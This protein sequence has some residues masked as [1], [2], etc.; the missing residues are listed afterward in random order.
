MLNDFR[1]GQYISVDSFIHK[2]DPRT[3]LLGLGI[4][5]LLVFL[6]EQW[7]SITG[8]ILLTLVLAAVTRVPLKY[9]FSSLK[10]LWP[11]FLF[12]LILNGLNIGEAQYHAGPIGL[13]QT[14]L[15]LGA[16]MVFR[17]AL[18]VILTSVFTFSTSP[19]TL[20]DGLE[21]MLK[22]LTRIGFPSHEITLMLTI[23]LRFIPT[24]MEEGDRLVKAV[25]ARGGALGSGGFV[26]RTK[27]L[28]P[29]LVPLFIGAFRRADE[30]AIAMEVRC[31]RGGTG[32]TCYRKVAFGPRDYL[33]IGI[34][35]GIALFAL[36]AR[37]H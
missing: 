6:T 23:A 27:S 1:V 30:L 25:Q 31:Y 17:L 37:I 10:A 8:E 22:P 9:Y 12:T 24:I 19:I 36:I 28:I 21:R 29:L 26:Q 20:A 5:S 14:G 18:I 15:Y 16:L 35:T 4:F 7:V 33:A 2:L 3:K 32:R 11:V 13:N 34:I